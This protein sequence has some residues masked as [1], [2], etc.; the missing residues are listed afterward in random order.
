M[1]VPLQGGRE[2]GRTVTTTRLREL[3]RLGDDVPESA[4][5]ALLDSLYAVADVAVDAALAKLGRGHD[6][7]KRLTGGVQCRA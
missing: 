2:Q 4:V 5:Q 6:G 1:I 7:R 3:M